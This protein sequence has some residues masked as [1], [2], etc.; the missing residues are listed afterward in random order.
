[1][2]FIMQK[3]ETTK[4]RNTAIS[5]VAGCFVFIFTIWLLDNC[6]WSPPTII[7][8][9]ITGIAYSSAIGVFVFTCLESIQ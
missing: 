1:M 7:L 2:K 4:I 8:A 5:V 3:K 9:G 6:S